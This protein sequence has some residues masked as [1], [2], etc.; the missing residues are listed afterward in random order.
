M[1]LSFLSIEIRAVKTLKE[2]VLIKKR[3]ISL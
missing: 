2:T 1:C 3:T